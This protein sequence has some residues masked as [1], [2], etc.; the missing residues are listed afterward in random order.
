[1]PPGDTDCPLRW[2]LID[3]EFATAGKRLANSCQ[4]PSQLV[5]LI[6]KEQLIFVAFINV[7]NFD[8]KSAPKG[9]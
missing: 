3:A 7:K 4:P 6:S 1:L 9:A 8:K 2:S 5:E